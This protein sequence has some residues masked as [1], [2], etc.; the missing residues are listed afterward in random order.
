MINKRKI[1]ILLLFSIILV[2]SISAIS[3]EDLNATDIQTADVEIHLEQSDSNVNDIQ[4]SDDEESELSDSNYDNILKGTTKSYSDLNRT[5]N[6][7]TDSLIVLRMIM[8]IM[9]IRT[10]HF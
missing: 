7:N 5:I 9:R 1:L 8:H 3:A 2:S 4:T 6:N 10:L